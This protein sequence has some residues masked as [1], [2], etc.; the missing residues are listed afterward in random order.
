MFC[1]GAIILPDGRPFIMGGT[2]AYDPF[3]GLPNTATYDPATGTWT[4]TGSLAVGRSAHSA[5]LLP[6]GRLLVVGG[7]GTC[8]RHDVRRH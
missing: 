1:N 8:P 4:E 6:D 7:G 2:E 3:F 5:T